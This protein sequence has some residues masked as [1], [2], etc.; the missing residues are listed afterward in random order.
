MALRPK[1]KRRLSILGLAFVLVFAAV[2]AVYLRYLQKRNADEADRAKRPAA[3][4][5]NSK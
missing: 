4:T 1:T 3:P 5:T 2:A